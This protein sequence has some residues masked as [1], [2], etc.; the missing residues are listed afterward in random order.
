MAWGTARQAA[1][2]ARR[3][4][5]AYARTT[6]HRLASP[7]G[8]RDQPRVRG[9]HAERIVQQEGIVG[10]APRVRGTTPGRTQSS[11]S[12]PEQPCVRGDDSSGKLMDLHVLG[13][14]PRSRG[15][16]VPHLDPVIQLGI[17]PAC[18][19]TTGSGR[20]SRRGPADQPRMRGRPDRAEH[21][22]LSAGTS[23]ACAGDDTC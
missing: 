4:S 11:G 18:A 12:R 23:P 3:N 1:Q 20:R 14:A 8:F 15:R 6:P 17:S 9:D 10:T 2:Q 16:R 13:P 21:R 5:P 19:G 22:P 7:A